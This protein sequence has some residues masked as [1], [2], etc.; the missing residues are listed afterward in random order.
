MAVAVLLS[1]K[2]EGPG[3]AGPSQDDGDEGDRVVPFL[4]GSFPPRLRRD[5]GELNESE[6]GIKSDKI[7]N[8]RIL[9]EVKEVGVSSWKKEALSKV[10][11]LS[12]I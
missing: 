8:A 7:W 2:A 1:G 10:T 9:R 12:G 11:C 5:L 3:T 6:A 4:S